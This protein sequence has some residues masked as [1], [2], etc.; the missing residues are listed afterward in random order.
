L[1]ILF[2]IFSPPYLA[3]NQTALTLFKSLAVVM[4]I[5]L[6]GWTISLAQPYIVRAVAPN[7]AAA[8]QQV[9]D[10]FGY[11]LSSLS[12]TV[13]VPAIYFTRLVYQVSFEEI[14]IRLSRIPTNVYVKL[15]GITFIFF[16]H[17]IKFP[18][19]YSI[20]LGHLV[21]T[22][23][24]PHFINICE[25]SRTP[26]QTFFLFQWRTPKRVPQ[27]VSLV[28]PPLFHAIHRHLRECC[29]GN[30]Q[31]QHRPRIPTAAA[32]AECVEEKEQCDVGGEHNCTSFCV[33]VK[34][35]FL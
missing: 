32:A 21:S 6:G 4:G 9:V 23:A 19:P 7:L 1:N 35:H 20:K 13:E 16:N 30:K 8:Q 28:L 15:N 27:T 11:C 5:Q 18:Y 22:F 3:S 33:D 17:T 2:S 12:S 10:H 25:K 29:H 24:H 14:P 26:N 31:L 34:S